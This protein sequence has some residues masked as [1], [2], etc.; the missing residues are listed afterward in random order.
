MTDHGTHLAIYLPDAEGNGIELAW[1]YPRER[2]PTSFEAMMR[3]NAPLTPPN[4]YRRC[5]TTHHPGTGRPRHYGRRH[6]HL[7]VAHI[8]PARQFYH[9]VLGFNLSF[10]LENVSGIAE[11]VAFFNAGD[12]HHHIGANTWLGEVRR[13]PGRTRLGCA[14]SPSCYP[15]RPHWSRCSAAWKRLGF[16]HRR[17]SREYCCGSIVKRHCTHHSKRAGLNNRRG[18]C[19]CSGRPPRPHSAALSASLLRVK[20]QHRHEGFLRHF[21]LARSSSCASCPSSAVRA[22]CACA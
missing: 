19:A 1:D 16:P 11:T 17:S 9:E 14:T 21:H 2:W 7:H 4:S 22:A 15:I 12:Y 8:P 3:R 5:T 18:G 10:D 6:V 20:P 13:R